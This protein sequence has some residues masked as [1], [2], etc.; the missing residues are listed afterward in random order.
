[1]R[2]WFVVVVALTAACPAKKRDEPVVEPV[3]VRVAADAG[4]RNPMTGVTIEGSGMHLDDDV[5]S[6]TVQPPATGARQGQI[7]ITLH[8]TPSGATA[9]V[10]GVPVGTTPTFWSGAA[11]GKPHDFTFTRPG[12]AMAR[13]RFVPIT[14]GV[15]H[16]RLDPIG[17]EVDAGVP[18]VEVTPPPPP[19]VH[20]A[21]PPPPTVIAPADAAPPPIDA[22]PAATDPFGP[23]Q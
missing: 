17:E 20:T 12:S 19:P 13:Y 6:R 16:A 7:Q 21:P 5:G 18:A 1:M 4:V 2:S 23:R 3:P 14:S 11:D 10:D 22:A 8:S 15:I 9:A